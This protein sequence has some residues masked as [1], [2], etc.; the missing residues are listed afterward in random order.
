MADIN[1]NDI[2]SILTETDSSGGRKLKVTTSASDGSG[3]LTNSDATF[4]RRVKVDLEGSGF[5]ASLTNAT[6]VTDP[7]YSIINDG[8]TGVLKTISPGTN[9]TFGDDGDTITINAAG[10]TYEI[11]GYVTNYAALPLGVGPS[12]PQIGDLVGVNNTTGTWVLGTR[13]LLGLYKRSAMTGVAAAD[14]GTQPFIDFPANID[15]SVTKFNDGVDPSKQMTFDISAITT[16]TD[17]TKIFQNTVGGTIA[18]L[19]DIPS[20]TGYVPYTGATG[21]VDLGAQVLTT[22]GSVT[23]NSVIVGSAANTIS[24]GSASGGNGTITSTSHATKGNILIAPDATG[25]VLIGGATATGQRLD[26]KQG[27]ST[28]SF[29]ELISNPGFSA[30]YHNQASPTDQNFS[31]YFASGSMAIRNGSSINIQIGTANKFVVTTA[32]ADFYAGVNVA[33]AAK[34][35]KGTPTTADALADVL[36]ATSATTQKGLVIQGKASQTANLFE[37][38]DSTGVAVTSI[39]PSG[40]VL[41]KKTSVLNINS[42]FEG[43]G[44]FICET[45]TVGDDSNINFEHV[46]GVGYLNVS[47]ISTGSYAP[48]VLRTSDAERIRI[49]TGGNVG[50]SQK[51][52]IGDGVTTPTALLHLK[53]GTTAA[54]T[55]PIKLTSGSLMTSPEAGAIEFLTDKFYAT[56][57]TGAARK[58]IAFNTGSTGW[59]M[60]NVTTDKVLD[61]NATSLDEVA[62]VLATLIDDLKAAGIISA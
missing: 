52:Y 44:L 50:I 27:T 26:V 5:I 23:A 61:C 35:L 14:Y 8:A 28:L 40:I 37:A 3:I 12:D 33:I 53:A 22:T 7:P 54:S 45:R 11:W 19:T 4:G 56:I 16:G 2:F 62:D 51:V 42:A 58:E 32:L 59:A 41:S 38:Q 17:R 46:G 24:L 30:I 43:K 49:Y 21:T 15:T 55:A 25:A 10:S 60:S 13:R 47:Y 9:I 29:G 36:F 6:A 18:E 57:T 20:L 31:M 1:L 48:L 39:T 34:L